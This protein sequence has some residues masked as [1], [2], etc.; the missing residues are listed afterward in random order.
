[1]ASIIRAVPDTIFLEDNSANPM[2]N[3]K[4]GTKMI[5][6]DRMISQILKPEEE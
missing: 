5:K 1:M 4:P 3:D 6:E 2:V